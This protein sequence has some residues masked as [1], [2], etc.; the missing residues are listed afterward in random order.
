MPCTDPVTN[1]RVLEAEEAAGEG[2]PQ[3]AVGETRTENFN[4]LTG[5]L[6]RLIAANQAQQA[7]TVELIAGTR[8]LKRHRSERRLDSSASSAPSPPSQAQQF[9]NT[10][11]AVFPNGSIVTGTTVR[12]AAHIIPKATSRQEF[13][14]LFQGIDPAELWSASNCLALD[15]LLHAEF[16]AHNV[17][18]RHVAGTSDTY[19]LWV[20]NREHRLVGMYHGKR[21]A[22]PRVRKEFLARHFA[23][24]AAKWG[25]IEVSFQV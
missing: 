22:L 25:A 12:G 24:C 5:V 15:P 21:A 14:A 8:H 9:E 23:Q 3:D 17:G 13:V 6:R 19:M 2:L 18:F 1:R 20:L 10:M 7:H 4:A 16:D 11:R